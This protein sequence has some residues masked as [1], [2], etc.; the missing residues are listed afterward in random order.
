MV[1][2]VSARWLDASK[3]PVAMSSTTIRASGTNRSALLTA[4]CQAA[5]EVGSEAGLWLP[6]ACAA[7]TIAKPA[8]AEQIAN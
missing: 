6:L 4:D 5:G 7:E 8:K 1:R 3:W 2:A